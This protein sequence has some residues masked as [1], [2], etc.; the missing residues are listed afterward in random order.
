MLRRTLRRLLPLVEAQ[1][2]IIESAEGHYDHPDLTLPKVLAALQTHFKAGGEEFTQVALQQVV[3]LDTSDADTQLI[4]DT[5]LPPNDEATAS[6]SAS[7]QR[8][9][10]AL[11]HFY[12]HN[13][14]IRERC[15]RCI[16]NMCLLEASSASTP[17]GDSSHP[18]RPSHVVDSL[19]AGG[20][21]ELT[22]GTMAMHHRLSDSGRC[23]T[24]LALLN[25][26]CMSHGGAATR[27]ATASAGA[28]ETVSEFV[29]SLADTATLEWSRGGASSSS[30]SSDGQLLTALD[31]SL[32]A[33][34][35]ILAAEA[36]DNARGISFQFEQA[37][38]TAVEAVVRVLLSTSA[39]IV[40]DG[41]NDGA[42]NATLPS[43]RHGSLDFSTASAT[44]QTAVVIGL[45]LLHKSWMSLQ[46]LCSHR[47][48]RP[49]VFEVLY[50]AANANQASSFVAVG[51]S[52]GAVQ[53]VLEVTEHTERRYRAALTTLLEA[54]LFLTTE[55][56]GLE[57]VEAVELV[58]L[59]TDIRLYVLQSLQ[60][61]TAPQLGDSAA[62]RE[63]SPSPLTAATAAGAATATAAAVSYPTTAAMNIMEVLTSGVASS[64][65]LANA[66]RVHAEYSAMSE[67]AESL[68]RR[69]PSASSPGRCLPAPYSATAFSLLSQA[70]SVLAHLAEAGDELAVSA[71]TVAALQTMLIASEELISRMAQSYASTLPELFKPS[72]TAES[73]KGETT[74][75]AAAELL[76]HD[77]IADDDRL[78]F[79][80]Q[81]AIA[82]Q[83]Y[84]I[85]SSVIRNS[86]SAT[87]VVELGIVSVVQAIERQ[88]QLV[89]MP[90]LAAAKVRYGSATD[91]NGG[92]KV[93]RKLGEEEVDTHSGGGATQP[94]IANTAEETVQR[95]LRLTV[96]FAQNLKLLTAA[97]QK[98]A[99]P[100]EE[101]AV[102]P[103]GR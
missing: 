91:G 71:N 21:V 60:Q 63:E 11:M 53:E 89:Y 32:G 28:M 43:R 76:P 45:P 88:L 38:F 102:V 70:L 47:P 99:T 65:A 103:A 44:Q 51:P 40:R 27:A 16:A 48:N 79:L 25:L 37:S 78:T 42:Y 13:P 73:E 82:G 86:S 26:L 59:Q 29:V 80:Q 57:A 10:I 41:R 18:G 50:E 95:L 19:V 14:Q 75:S 35:A 69:H 12:P 77:R 52:G 36:P 92:G 17:D 61:L 74:A 101:A 98:V 96:E 34:T 90:A 55:L 15:C 6:S 39:Y 66:V 33:L 64:I 7:L 62:G 20:A 24:A 93:E 9:V 30:P 8:L 3:R 83:S 2:L 58:R 1:K 23:W 100:T 67:E 68:Q 81:C 84:V 49:L 56:E 46:Q 85:L 5:Y 72:P 4:A 94:W 31:A 87:T 97:A 54:A 22:L